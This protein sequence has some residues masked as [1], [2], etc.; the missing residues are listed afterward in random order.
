MK[1]LDENV[2]NNISTKQY[3][4]RTHPEERKELETGLIT[5]GANSRLVVGGE[6]IRRMNGFRKLL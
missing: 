3:F 4:P 5:V 6:R 2:D 1:N